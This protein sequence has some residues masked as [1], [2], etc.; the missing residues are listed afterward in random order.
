M[1]L[2]PL[3]AA[4]AL[5]AQA[6]WASAAA[7]GHGSGVLYVS[8]GG[9]SGN[10]DTSC[11]TAAYNSISSAVSAASPGGTVIVC[12]GTYAESVT[13]A[14]PLTLQGKNATVDATG[15]PFGIGVIVSRVTVTGFT[16]KNALGEGIAV[17]PGGALSGSCG[18][19]GKKPCSPVTGVTVS[20]NVV[21]HDNLGY[22]PPA[23]C[24][25]PLYPGDCGGGI[26]LDT[27]AWSH[28][29][30]NTVEHNVDGIL[31][32]DDFGPTHN[33][34]IIGNTAVDNVNECGITLP[35]HNPGAATAKQLP[36]GNYVV[37]KL[38]P[39]AGG[40]YDNLVAGNTS[41][42][43]GTAGFKANAAGSGAGIL[44]ASAGPGTAV[45]NNTVTGNEASGNGLA[46]VVIH[47]HYQ[48]G[49]Y[50]QGNKIVRNTIGRNNITGDNLDTPYT[51][52]DFATTGILVFSAMPIGVTV[53]HNTISRNTDGIWTTP[54]V[55][56]HGQN[57][58]TKVRIH[59][60]RVR[61]PFGSALTTASVTS[62]GATLVGFAVPNG[63]P[64]TAYFQW[65]TSTQPPF[66]TATPPK[67]VGS[68]T[69]IVI[70]TATLSHLT[71]NTTYYYWLVITN[72]NGTT[73]GVTQSFKTAS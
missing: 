40:V 35:S 5:V 33:N 73:T 16:V 9:S 52:A 46:G 22:V 41:D 64:T 12:K 31:V 14:K 58:F 45:Y 55:T 51:G 23:G 67:K 13:V 47:A 24:S 19:T 72:N 49:E 1:F 11:R 27:A 42:G 20:R 21:D 60:Y 50:L 17:V 37:T 54:N 48:G 3:L 71:P 7:T 34:A 32:V 29:S 15:K 2:A 44:L 43:N 10:P 18:G 8:P 39:G 68:G 30:W 26:L 36:N 56:L 6:G 25:A 65:G 57:T 53:A 62:T 59:V 61:A 4:G 66:Y 63:R 69:K 70:T 28:V 38:N